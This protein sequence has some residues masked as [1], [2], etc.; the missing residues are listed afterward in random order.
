MNMH[1]HGKELYGSF[2]RKIDAKETTRN[3]VIAF[4]MYIFLFS[5][6]EERKTLE[7]S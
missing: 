6:R 4:L 5:I 1:I 2:Y 3:K 7:C